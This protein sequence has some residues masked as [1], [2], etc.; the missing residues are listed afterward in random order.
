MESRATAA[1]DAIRE[2][3]GFL[4]EDVGEQR[5]VVGVRLYEGAPLP[6]EYAGVPLRAFGK[7]PKA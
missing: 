7:A 3:G 6:L 2:L 1:H 4:A 5:R